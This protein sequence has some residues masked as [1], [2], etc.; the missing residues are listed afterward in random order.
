MV[1]VVSDIP[2][3]LSYPEIINLRDCPEVSNH[4]V[5]VIKKY[6]EDGLSVLIKR[7]PKDQV[8]VSFGDFDGNMIDITNTNHRYHSAINLF[9]SKYNNKFVTLMKLINLPQA[10]FYISVNDTKLVL[11]DIRLGLDKFSG[12]GMIRDVFKNIIDTQ[13][14]VSIVHLDDNNLQLI[15]SHTGQYN[16][17][18]I[19]KTSIFKTIDRG[20]KVLPAY[21]RAVK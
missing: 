17:D 21:A 14:V 19:I 18:L 13:E 4:L 1:R 12:P 5:Y 7:H 11:V 20:N 15:K 6:N 16:H 10:I 9:L 8:S 2:S 3:L